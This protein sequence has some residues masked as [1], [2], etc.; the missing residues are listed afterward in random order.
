MLKHLYIKNYALI[1][2]LDIDFATG[3]SV[4]QA[5]ER[6]SYSAPSGCYWGSALT[7]RQ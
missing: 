7:Q 2:V 3:F 6:V 5:R 1:D 4:K